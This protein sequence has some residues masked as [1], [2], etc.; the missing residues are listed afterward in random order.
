ELFY[1]GYFKNKTLLDS[2]YDY[3]EES[4]KQLN[5]SWLAAGFVHEIRNLL[6]SL[7]GF[8]QLLQS[9]VTQKEEYYR[10]M[11]SEVEKLEYITDMILTLAIQKVMNIYKES[12]QH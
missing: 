2:L 7:K 8:L 11:I 6:T 5:T 9:G 12:V 10:V 3:L 4:E 1:I